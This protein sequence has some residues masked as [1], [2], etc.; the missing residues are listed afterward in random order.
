MVSLGL[1]KKFFFQTFL[2]STSLP[3]VFFYWVVCCRWN[4]HRQQFLLLSTQSII[5]GRR[6]TPMQDQYKTNK[7][8][9]NIT[10]IHM[11]VI[12]FKIIR[13]ITPLF[14]RCEAMACAT[15]ANSVS[16]VCSTRA[17]QWQILTFVA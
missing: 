2:T 11:T 3:P 17:R 7:R 14:Y 4:Y 12:K 15:T 5:V 6:P 9:S 8:A 1:K 16:L 13:E 10:A